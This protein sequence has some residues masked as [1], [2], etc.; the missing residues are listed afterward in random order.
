MPNCGQFGAF[1]RYPPSNRA[2]NAKCL[3]PARNRRRSIPVIAV[4]MRSMLRN[5]TAS[6]GPLQKRTG[7]S[8]GFSGRLHRL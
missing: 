4:K 7:P 6:R 1:G 8:G 5:C 3:C 2:S